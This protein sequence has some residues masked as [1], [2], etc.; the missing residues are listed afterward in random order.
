MSILCTDLTVVKFDEGIA[1]IEEHFGTEFALPATAEKGYIDVEITLDTSG[2]HSSTPP[3]HT[4]S[5]TSLSDFT[6]PF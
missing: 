6:P 1:G 2:G 4:A 3:D 5:K